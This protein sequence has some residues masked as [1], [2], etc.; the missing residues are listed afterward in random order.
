MGMISPDHPVAGSRESGRSLRIAWTACGPYH[1]LRGNA[2]HDRVPH[3]RHVPLVS[4][5]V[6]GAGP[7]R[8]EGRMPPR[9]DLH[10]ARTTSSAAEP[11]PSGRNVTS[12]CRRPL[13]EVRRLPAEAGPWAWARWSR[14]SQSLRGGLH[15]FTL[16]SACESKV[17]VI[18]LASCFE[19]RFTVGAIAP[20]TLKA[21]PTAR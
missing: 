8:G 10:G 16:P 17:E 7:E 9:E 5:W 12:H 18:V 19:R 2:V 1:E 6:P 21:T 14:C 4:A 3:G 11:E 20:R 15:T 13:D